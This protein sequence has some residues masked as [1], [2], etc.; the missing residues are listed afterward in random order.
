MNRCVA[1]GAA[2]PP[3]RIRVC[4]KEVSADRTPEDG[5]ER[6]VQTGRRDEF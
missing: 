5:E 4:F 2:S 3:Q 6:V 1:A